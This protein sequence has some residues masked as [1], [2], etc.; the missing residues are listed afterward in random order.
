[1]LCFCFIV[2]LHP[3][4]SQPE[5]LKYNTSKG[6]S[7]R[8][9]FCT[10]APRI[11]LALCVF[12][13]IPKGLSLISV[14]VSTVS[15]A[16]NLSSK[17]SNAG[18]TVSF[19]F[20]R[21]KYRFK[22]Q[23]NWGSIFCKTIWGTKFLFPKTFCNIIFSK[24]TSETDQSVLP[25]RIIRSSR[26]HD[27][28]ATENAT[29]KYNF[30]LLV[31]L[32]NYFNLFNL[33]SVAELSSNGTGGNSIYFETEKQKIY[34]RVLTLSTNL[35]FGNFTLLFGLVRRTTVLKFITQLQGLCFSH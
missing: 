17:I 10:S 11:M 24:I 30:A 29:W 5:L 12:S 35:E 21:G 16:Q 13:G 33:C 18:K 26:K 4:L 8:K 27:G 1:M 25:Y 22:M 3:Y 2:E 14:D 23:K 7:N 20:R 9:V 19:R 6:E 28:N 15:F 31:Q 32:Y 34:R